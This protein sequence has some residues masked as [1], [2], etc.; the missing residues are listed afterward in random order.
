MIL[1]AT[2][3]VA[4]RRRPTMLA[5]ALDDGQLLQRYVHCQDETAFAAL[6]TR[7]GPLV[8]GVCR[9]V[10]HHQQDTE[11]AFQAAFVVLAR[12]ARSICKQASLASWLYKVAY[13][14]ALRA[15]TTNARRRLPEQ[16]IQPASAA[17]SP[18][19]EV[20]LAELRRVLDEEVQRLPEKYRTP[21][22]L[23]Y[24]EGQTNE[25]AAEQLCCPIGTVKI[26]LAR[27]REL[28]RKRLTRRGVGLSALVLTAGL[29]Q[30][31][32]AAVPES[33]GAAT[34][35]AVGGG[36]SSAVAQLARAALEALCWTKL[37]IAAAVLLT[38]MVGMLADGLSQRSQ[39]AA[40]QPTPARHIRPAAPLPAEPPQYRETPTP[41]GSKLLLVRDRQLNQ[42]SPGT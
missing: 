33:L 37:K 29:L 31:A 39:V 34:L 9:R 8:L 41:S 30:S 14:I 15:R 22:L 32:S 4:P 35:Q 12:K 16:R 28:L 3:S 6:V 20:V 5:A 24:L 18:L 1:D 40:A 11:D 23:C 21:I 42:R 25:K 7:H 10:L 17:P 36:C 38:V 2:S 19:G 27:G 26:R 13:R